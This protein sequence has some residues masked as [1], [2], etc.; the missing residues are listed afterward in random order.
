MNFAA[1]VEKL[2]L[3]FRHG[4]NLAASQLDQE[5]LRIAAR[6]DEIAAKTSAKPGR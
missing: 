4:Q 3:A 2:R 5:H 1:E 6:I